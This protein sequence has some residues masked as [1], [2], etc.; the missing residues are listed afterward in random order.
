MKNKRIL[1]FALIALPLIAAAYYLYTLR[2]Q[3]SL[4][5]TSPPPTDQ[6]V[7]SNQQNLPQVSGISLPE[8]FQIHYYAQDVP[9][10]RSLVISQNGIVYVGSRDQGNVYALV[11][12]DDDMVADQVI[13][14]D[15]S[16]NSPNG[17]ALYNGDLY[18]AQINKITKYSDID[19]TY[20]DN[21]EP[22]LVFD[23]LPSDSSHGWKYIAFGPD[24]KL[25]VP[26]GA[27][28]NICD[29]DAPYAAL[30]RLN[31]DGTGFETVAQ[32]IRNTVGFDWH[33][34]TDTLWFTDN[35]RDWLGDNKPPDELNKLSSI[36][37]HFGFPY[38]HGSDISDPDFGEDVDCDQYQDPQQELGPHV[39]ALGISFY[40]HDLFPSSY[41]DKVFI[42]EHGSWNR[43]TPIGYR[44]T[45]VDIKDDQASNYQVFASGWLKEDGSSWGRPVDITSMSDGSLLVSDDASGAVYRIF[46]TD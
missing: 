19:T 10:A 27:P 4:P 43:S 13:T 32:G 26:I 33:P 38:C 21:P 3:V 17:V 6:A 29:P 7:D 41:Q 31:P 9:G 44:I 22:Q 37:Q 35:G 40:E 5:K 14:V 20:A 45:T 11:D 28:C 18:V 36:G 23:Q 34:D 42:A 1:L 30:H 39:A 25:Y 2:S 8:G 24:D 16:L 15:S 12:E 46:Y